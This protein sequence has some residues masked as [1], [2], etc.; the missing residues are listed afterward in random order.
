VNILNNLNTFRSGLA[1]SWK[2]A[3][4]VNSI[5]FRID[6]RFATIS[7][8]WSIGGSV[9]QVVKITVFGF[10]IG[11]V[12][13]GFV[14]TKQ[15]DLNLLICIGAVMV[16]W[17]MSRQAAQAVMSHFRSI[18]NL[19]FSHR[20]REL[21]IDK[22]NSLD[23]GRLTHRPFVDVAESAAEQSQ[24]AIRELWD[25]QR[26]FV[27]NVF[28]LCG[29]VG[30]VSVLDPILIF[31]ALIPLVPEAVCSLRTERRRQKAWEDQILDR[32]HYAMF[33]RWLVEAERLIQTSLLGKLA[34][35]RVKH[36]FYRDEIRRAEKVNQDQSLREKMWLTLFSGIVFAVSCVYLGFRISEGSLSI[37]AM[38][39]LFGSLDT[40][41]EALDSCIHDF[42]VLYSG[43]KDYD[44]H[45]QFMAAMPMIMQAGS[46]SAVIGRCPTIEF[47]GVHFSYPLDV[48]YTPPILAGCSFSIP[49]GQKIA[50]VGGNGSGKSTSMHLL[51]RRYLPSEGVV[52]IGDTPLS[53]IVEA[54]WLS[55]VAYM[56]QSFV[57]PGLDIDMAITFQDRD[58]IDQTRFASAVRIAGLDEFVQPLTKGYQTRL[59]AH[60]P[61]GV[62]FSGGQRQRLML[63]AT[64]YRLLSPEVHIGIFDE[65]MSSCDHETKCRFYQ[66]VSTLGGKTVILV[67]H[68]PGF[69]H[70]FD[71]VLVM[72]GGRVVGDITEPEQIRAFQNEQFL[73]K[74]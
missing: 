69:L 58:K 35:M 23:I 74:R 67:V 73:S 19:N 7:W 31:V 66:A 52:L 47:R 46:N 53:E 24:P 65:P 14:H 32:R 56:T 29:S 5:I 15:F 11:Q 49:A 20:M 71:R 62:E 33:S 72:R 8:L 38:V 64:L 45:R 3:V 40:F 48:G 13:D 6:R 22:M 60:W 61:G 59:G 34:F 2:T 17:K 18:F 1:Q 26:Q 25:S 42:I 27:A 54:R 57:L 51:S 12:I 70:L 4:E 30:L 41:R 36:V 9:V 43:D 28:G 21:R 55:H 37:S 68:D 16:G 39:I 63:A 50:I 44:Y 10:G